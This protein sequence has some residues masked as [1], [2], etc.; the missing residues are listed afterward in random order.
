MPKRQVPTI[1]RTRMALI[2]GL[3]ARSLVV[4][5]TGND[6]LVTEVRPPPSRAVGGSIVA[7]K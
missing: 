7:H 5:L 2:D 1:K 6:E 3:R 4:V